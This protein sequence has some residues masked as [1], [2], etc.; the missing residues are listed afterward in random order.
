MS[1]SA[2]MSEADS[3]TAGHIDKMLTARLYKVDFQ[4]A[5]P[6]L[7][8]SFPL[9]YPYYISVIGD[10]VESFLPYMGR[11]YSTPYGGGEGLRF[12]APVSNYRESFKKNGK[13]EIE[14][15]AITGEDKYE[16]SLTVFPLGQCDLSITPLRKQSI[17][18]SGRVDLDPEFEAV[19]MSD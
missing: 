17:S 11:A 10:R 6:M 16:F 12:A 1:K 8:P 7:A 3:A 18:F 4:R 15:T 13:R 2:V 14:F 5:Y 9:D 19:R